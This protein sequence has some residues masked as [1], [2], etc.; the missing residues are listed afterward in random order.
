MEAVGMRRSLDFPIPD[1]GMAGLPDDVTFHACF[2]PT[3]RCSCRMPMMHCQA[4]LH[5]AISSKGDNRDLRLI[6]VT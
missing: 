3:D 5:K 4:S 6:H 1:R 2:S